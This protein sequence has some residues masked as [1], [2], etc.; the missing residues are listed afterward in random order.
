MFLEGAAQPALRRRRRRATPAP[1]HL[2]ALEQL[3]VGAWGLLLQEHEAFFAGVIVTLRH[4][5]FRCHI[6]SV[7][8]ERGERVRNYARAVKRE[9]APERECAVT[10]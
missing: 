7:G 5:F 10:R 2:E 1:R 3:L 6:A 4:L 9:R 8:R